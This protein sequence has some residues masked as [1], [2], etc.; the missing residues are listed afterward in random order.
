MYIYTCALTLVRMSRHITMFFFF[1]SRRR[2]TR[3]NCDWSSDVCSSHLP[4]GEVARHADD[5]QAPVLEVVSLL[6]VESEYAV[7]KRFVGRDQRRDLLQPE[8]LARGQAVAAVGCPQAP[9][10]AAHHDE[11]IEERGRLVDLCGQTLGVR[12]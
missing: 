8:H 7:G 10:L 2:H 5:L 4:L 6:G 9:V 12:G 1:S 3:W 11:R